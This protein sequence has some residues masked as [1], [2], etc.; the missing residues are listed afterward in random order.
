MNLEET[1]KKIAVRIN[2]MNI[3][4]YNNLRRKAAKPE[5]LFRSM[6]KVFG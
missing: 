5:F 3:E 2:P 4:K 6:D 1:R